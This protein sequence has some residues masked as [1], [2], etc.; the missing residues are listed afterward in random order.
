MKIKNRIPQFN[1]GLHKELIDSGWTPLKEPNNIST[2]FLASIPFMIAAGLLS[3]WMLNLLSPFSLREFGIE[4][5]AVM[6]TIHPGIILSF[7]MLLI[8]HELLH[9]V[10]IPNFLRSDNTLI[11]LTWFGGFVATEEKIPKGRFLLITLA[12]FVIISIIIPLILSTFGLLTV[13]L[14]ILILINSLASSVDLLNFLLV[15]KQAPKNAIL[16]SNGPR[17]YWRI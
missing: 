6:I 9:L 5:D 2:A 12:P 16:V 17:T 1:E 13:L 4:D 3:F 8:L 7:L 14:K 11:G 10:L 15:S